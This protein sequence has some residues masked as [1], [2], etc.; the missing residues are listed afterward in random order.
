MKK[1]LLLAYSFPPVANAESIVT[2]KMVKALTHQGWK[3]LVCTVDSRWN[4]DSKDWGL[5]DL[6]PDDM[7]VFRSPPLPLI[8]LPRL[9]RIMK[10]KKIATLV[11]SLPDKSIFWYP[12]ALFLLR[13]MLRDPEIKVLHSRSMPLAGHFLGLYAKKKSGLPWV[14]HFCDPW[15]DGPFYSVKWDFLTRLHARWERK[16][17]SAAD[18]VTFTTETACKTVMAK[19]PTEWMRKCHVI[20]HGFVTFPSV[21]T[22]RKLL[23]PKVLNIVYLGN[24][25]GSRSPQVLF[26]ALKIIRKESAG[27]SSLRIWFVGR[28]PHHSYAA[29]AKKYGIDHMICLKEAV[30][31][32][33]AMEYAQGADVLLT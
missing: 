20:P 6:L 31:Y 32:Q 28:M 22:S 1:Q 18:A 10:L 12:A 13:K 5:M 30:P 15:L 2:A 11:E 19:Y 27:Q 29:L 26:Q 4:S 16:F 8:R 3:S 17:I 33:T 14:V 21:P 23:D 7:E 24:F 9:L 25:Y